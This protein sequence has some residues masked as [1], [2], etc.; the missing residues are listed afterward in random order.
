MLVPGSVA[1]VTGASSGIGRQLAR[2][3]AARGATVVA[4]ARREE[5]LR[6]LVEELAAAGLRAQGVPCDVADRAQV[7][8]TAR[9][10]LD[11]HGRVDILV[12]NA[13]IP[14]HRRFSDC[15]VEELEQVIRVNYLG[16]VYWMKAVLPSM[17]ARRRGSIVN[18]ASVAGA[19]PWTWEAGYSASKA[20]VI[21]LTEAVR[22][23][24]ALD[25]I[26]TCWVNPGLVRT[27]IFTEDALRH[28]PESAKRSFLEPTVL[29]R[30]IVE[31]I[32]KEKA[33][34]TVPRRMALPG[35][36]RHVV[37]G[38]YRAGLRKAFA[39]TLRRDQQAGVTTA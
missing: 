5:R 15:T 6:S 27:E 4:V 25:G 11:D 36:L 34:I 18:V 23:E 37:P 39:A 14:L 12:N 31:A 19:V 21:A 22:P 9:R 1:V 38:V 32:E 29:S 33:G 30:A 10:V 13:G 16:T 24:L 26:H 7:E 35:I 28:L 17:R 8:A 3:L 20:A 2:D